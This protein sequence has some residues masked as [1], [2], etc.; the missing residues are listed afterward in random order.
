MTKKMVREVVGVLRNDAW[1]SVVVVF[2][3]ISFRKLFCT[4][5]QWKKCVCVC[6]CV[7]VCCYCSICIVLVKMK[8]MRGFGMTWI[9]F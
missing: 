8:K 1:Y 5:F 6:V 7:C 3:F 4:S 2:G 9:G